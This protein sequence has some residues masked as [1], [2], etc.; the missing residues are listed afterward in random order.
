MSISK[1]KELKGEDKEGKFTNCYLGIAYQQNRL[2]AVNK[3]YLAMIWENNKKI[4]VMDSSKPKKIPYQIPYLI[5]P[6]NALDLEFSPFNDN[7]L[8]SSSHSSVLL[9]KIPEKGVTENIM[10]EEGTYAKHN[11]KVLFIN[12]NP[13]NSD[14]ICS[15]TYTGE[16]HVWNQSK[17][18]KENEIKLGNPTN[19]LWNPNG[20]LIGA[21]TQ[22]KNMNVFDPRNKGICYRNTITKNYGSINFV[23]ADNDNFLTTDSNG[24]HTSLKLWDIRKKDSEVHNIAIDYCS[25][26]TLLTNLESKLLYIVEKD[27]N[28]IHVYDYNENI[29]KKA[30]TF[31]SQDKALC[32]VLFN[33]KSIELEWNEV[34]RLARYSMNKL[35]YYVSFKM[36]KGYNLSRKNSEQNLTDNRYVQKKEEIENKSGQRKDFTPYRKTNIEDRSTLSDNNQNNKSSDKLLYA[37]T[38]IIKH[39]TKYE[40]NNNELVNNNHTQNEYNDLYIKYNDLNKKYTEKNESYSKLLNDN[41]K[42]QSEFNQ[43]KKIYEESERK[44]KEINDKYSQSIKELTNKYN[45]IEIEKN[46]LQ[47]E[48]NTLYYKCKQFVDN[49][50]KQLE[51]ANKEQ[52]KKYNVLYNLYS[53]ENNKCK[54]LNKDIAELNSQ[55]KEKNKNIEELE[56]KVKEKENETRIIKVKKLKRN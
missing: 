10:K 46:K 14:K 24:K 7:I 1:F 28:C 45:T 15:S 41:T 32:T 44:I 34:D 36:N 18:E 33:K 39:N 55:L 19:V 9:W 26:N 3:K 47:N 29:L 35:V 21:T 4:I 49:Q 22:D 8:A 51:I 5:I 27:K 40:N 2:I 43:N 53:E 23:W 17:L 48:Y 11:N 38:Q 25:N 30:T 37:K 13:V 54:S 42:L 6:N 12:F 16:I 56:N 20:S 52:E 31:I 50:N